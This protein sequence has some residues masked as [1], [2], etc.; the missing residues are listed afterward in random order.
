MVSCNH[1]NC[2]KQSSFMNRINL[3]S[4]TASNKSQQC[5]SHVWMGP[6]LLGYQQVLRGI[7]ASCSM[8]H[9]G[10][11]TVGSSNLLGKVSKSFHIPHSM[12]LP[13]FITERLERY[14]G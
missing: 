2:C 9:P 4:T 1:I 8:T 10:T 13:S 12:L 14:V 7:N 6:T 11:N 5:F 3:L